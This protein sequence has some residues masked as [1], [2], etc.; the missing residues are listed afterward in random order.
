[1]T[2]YQSVDLASQTLTDTTSGAPSLETGASLSGNAD[3]DSVS[4]RSS[5]TLAIGIDSG[6]VVTAGDELTIDELFVNAL[7]TDNRL[8]R[9]NYNCKQQ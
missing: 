9:H 5:T 6:G 2:F 8:F 3:V 7:G 1:M 4:Y